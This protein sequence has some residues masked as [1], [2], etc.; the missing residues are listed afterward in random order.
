MIKKKINI[1]VFSGNRAEYGLLFPILNELKMDHIWNSSGLII[2]SPIVLFNRR[3]V[4]C[5]YKI[6]ILEFSCIYI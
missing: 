2:Y 4:Y 1:S 6:N 5:L 3:R